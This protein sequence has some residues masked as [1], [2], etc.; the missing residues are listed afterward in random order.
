MDYE[1]QIEEMYEAH[2]S[3]VRTKMMNLGLDEC[4][5]ILQELE[6]TTEED[7]RQGVLF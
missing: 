6:N 7:S 2:K 4:K 3:E 1:T 5:K